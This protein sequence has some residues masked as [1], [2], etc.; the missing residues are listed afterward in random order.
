MKF[1]PITRLQIKRQLRALAKQQQNEEQ[2]LELIREQP[3]KFKMVAVPN[4]VTPEGAKDHT[5]VHDGTFYHIFHIVVGAGWGYG[6]EVVLGHSISAD[7]ITWRR[8]PDLD[9]KDSS[10]SSHHLWAPHVIKHGDLWY[11]FYTGVRKVPGGD[12]YHEERIGLATSKNLFDWKLHNGDGF[13]LDGQADFTSWG[14]GERWANDC[15]DP[16]V[17]NH[18]GSW[19]MLLNVRLADLSAYAIGVWQSADL[20]SWTPL[21]SLDGSQGNRAESPNVL[22]DGSSI[23][24]FWTRGR[25]VHSVGTDIMGTFSTPE[26]LPVGGYANEILRVGNKNIYTNVAG[27]YTIRFRELTSLDPITID[28]LKVRVR[29]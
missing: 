29:A 11:M 12:A 23:H 24:V 4:Y 22:L 19:Y 2:R 1:F 28:T 3:K 13:L 21:G 25:V 18:N 10:W 5:L 6:G 17:F 20:I 27:N 14:S 9:F 26:P 16:F 8:Q 15:R 7:L